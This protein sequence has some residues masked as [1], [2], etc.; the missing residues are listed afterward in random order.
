MRTD[1]SHDNSNNP[2]NLDFNFPSEDSI[3]GSMPYGSLSNSNSSLQIEDQKEEKSISF[4]CCDLKFDPLP[5]NLGDIIFFNNIFE[6]SVERPKKIFDV[7]IPERNTLFNKKE[8]NPPSFPEEKKFLG[9]KRSKERRKR[10]DNK[11]NMH[12]KMKRAFFNFAVRNNLNKLLID[13]GSKKYFEKFP[14]NF[15]SDVDRKR[16]KEILDKTLRQ[17]FEDEKIYEKE[18]KTGKKKFKHNLQVVR[19]EI[20]NRELKN[21][22]DKT[23]RVLYEE[24]LNSDEFKVEEI[25]RLRKKKMKDDYIEGYINLSNHLIQFF[26]N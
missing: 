24:Y 6:F 26:E 22:L 15:V 9:S 4:P 25:N 16:N 21:V 12:K 10:K 5:N 19:S 8:D 13:T 17:L 1:D 18:K 14:G 20:K 7:I 23:F 3:N 11:D 2:F